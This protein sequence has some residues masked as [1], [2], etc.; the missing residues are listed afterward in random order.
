MIIV[1]GLVV[2]QITNKE[3]LYNITNKELLYHVSLA[4]IKYCYC[5]C[6]NMVDV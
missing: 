6:G 4:V 5:N 2:I 1:V 3:L